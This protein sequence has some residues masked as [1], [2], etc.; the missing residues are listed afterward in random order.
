MNSGRRVLK[1][2]QQNHIFFLEI[3]SGLMRSTFSQLQSFERVD[4]PSVDLVDLADFADGSGSTSS[5]TFLGRLLAGFS[6]VANSGSIS[7]FLIEIFFGLRPRFGGAAGGD[8]PRV[9]MQ[10]STGME[11]SLCGELASRGPAFDFD[12]PTFLGRSSVVSNFTLRDFFDF[13]C[14]GSSPPATS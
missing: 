14:T 3:L 13:F 2:N 4:L 11:L 9:S 5:D 7:V 8:E 12:F 1:T 10:T 6:V